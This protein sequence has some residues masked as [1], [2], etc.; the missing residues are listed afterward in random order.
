MT[1]LWFRWSPE[2]SV[3][4]RFGPSPWLLRGDG[5]LQWEDILEQEAFDIKSQTIP[6]SFR[7]LATRNR[8]AHSS[9]HPCHDTLPHYKPKQWMRPVDF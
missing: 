9:L 7:F 1:R 6:L 4:Y 2:G 5:L 8:A 3:W